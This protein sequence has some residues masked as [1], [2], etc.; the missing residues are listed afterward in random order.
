MPD[1]ALRDAVSLAL[2]RGRDLLVKARA[3]QDIPLAKR[4]HDQADAFERLA[5]RQHLG[6]EWI[7]LGH[8]VKIEALGLLGEL[9]AALPK[10]KGGGEKGVGRRG[11]QNAGTD[12]TRIPTTTYAELG[13]DKKTAMVARWLAEQPSETREAIAQQETTLSA[14]RAY[15][16]PPAFIA[17]VAPG[18]PSA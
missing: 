3:D 4:V 2:T 18:V 9:M 7:G 8:A 11:K 13:I 17:Q 12:E 15:P 10:A 5:K 6:E 16:R 1:L 14:A